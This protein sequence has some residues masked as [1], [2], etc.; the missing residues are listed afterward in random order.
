MPSVVTNFSTA[1]M[2]ND[3]AASNDDRETAP[4]HHAQYNLTTYPDAD[5]VLVSKDDVN[6]NVHKTVL[7]LS[8]SFFQ[9]MLELPTKEGLESACET[10]PMSE[11]S[12]LLAVLFNLTYP[13]KGLPDIPTFM[14][15]FDVAIA[16]EK[17]NMQGVLQLLSKYVILLRKQHQQTYKPIPLY[18]LARRVSWDEVERLAATDTLSSNI[19]NATSF[20]ALGETTRCVDVWS[21]I[22]LHDWHVLRR[23][24][25][26]DAIDD[27]KCWPLGTGSY[28]KLG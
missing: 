28:P 16:A 21:L 17:Y 27:L 4:V 24:I 23:S 1:N 9:D 10:I 7:R 22:R 3:V 15:F 8:S 20:E 19:A 2:E 12:D 5:L 25:V 6:F 18:A 26:L 11:H 14:L 13:G